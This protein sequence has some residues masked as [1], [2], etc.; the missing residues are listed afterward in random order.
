MKFFFLM[1]SMLF[2]AIYSMGQQQTVQG[3]VTDAESGEPLMGATVVIAGSNQGVITDVDGGFEL[4][5]DS[6]VSVTIRFVGYTSYE[7]ILEPSTNQINITL[8]PGILSESV[9]IK[10]IRADADD[11][12]S[13][14]T[15]SAKEL[16]QEFYGQDGAFLLERLTPSIVSFSE[17]GTGFTNYGQIRLRG[18]DQ[19]RI[20]ITLNGVPLNDMID[21][22]VF[23]SNFTDFGN[24]IESVQ[25]QRG[26][27]S[28]TNGT[29][30]YAGSI[31]F[32][33]VNLKNLDTGAE[34]QLQAGSFGT[35][36]GSLEV[37]SGLID[38]KFSFY[39]RISN[40]HSDGYRNHSGSDSYSLFF[41]GAFFGEKDLVKITGFTGRTKNELAYSPVWIED[42]RRDPKTNYVSTND[43]D[44]FG[45]QFLQLQY[46]RWLS[47]R[48]SL[49]STLYY[50]GAGG[51]FPFGFDDGSGFTQI[52]YPLYNDHYGFLSTVNHETSRF[53]VDGGVHAYTFRRKNEEA[54]VPNF[55]DPY[56]SDETQ[57]DEISAFAKGEYALG[58]FK[59]SGD[60]QIRRV[61]LRLEP[62]TNFLGF[63]PGVPDRTWTFVNPKIGVSYAFNNNHLIYASFGRTG[64]EPT[65]TDILAAS[66]IGAG[67]L[68]QV[69]NTE[70]VKA[71]YVNNLELGVRRANQFYSINANFFYM[72]FDNE[73]APIGVF[74]PEIFGSL[75]ENIR[76]SERYGVEMDLSL[77]P[78]EGIELGG[79]ATYM[80]GN[81]S[82]LTL[83]GG[84]D[85]LTDKEHILTPEWTI[86]QYIQYKYSDKWS[87]RL[88]GQYLSES[89]LELT[90]DPELVLPSF[91]VLNAQ[92][93]I[94]PWPW[95]DVQ[96]VMNNL[97]DKQ[98]F[99][100]G[101]PVD[102]DFDGVI[103]GPGY[104]VQ[105]PRNG[106]I[107]VRLKV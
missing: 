105:P 102:L 45:Q 5:I 103:E 98:Y 86:Q 37:S 60:L 69:L 68:D 38:D 85:V 81:I 4:D 73:I 39:S 62:D 97:F 11:P 49:T 47:S 61:I 66:F 41:S 34:V 96:L 55:S 18:I 12:V 35:Y 79:F 25:V 32:E 30:S 106:Y 53:N 67:N 40:I 10:G 101:T 64:R 7:G 91:Y 78:L 100:Y 9:V 74:V 28:S 6:P 22:G 89:F 51:D 13:Q 75:R 26:V 3:I 87:L 36:R 16:E 50:G 27:G 70:S 24:S 90:N 65:R 44:D 17:S 107:L 19:T 42:I 23:F 57:K 80:R 56:Y 84:G 88:S 77:K 99:T 93:N 48:T 63:E 58:K 83:G 46:V 59:I 20:N 54:I 82:R 52:N 104:I 43:V 1:A 21:Q 2:L 33:S 76:E 31:N 29:S 72:D 8:K 95:V 92:L 94:S 14:T 15:I 71:E